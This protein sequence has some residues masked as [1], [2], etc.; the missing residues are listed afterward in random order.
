MLTMV[1]VVVAD[2]VMEDVE[3]RALAIYFPLPIPASERGMQMTHVVPLE[4]I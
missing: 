1:S 3:S 2:L 4:R